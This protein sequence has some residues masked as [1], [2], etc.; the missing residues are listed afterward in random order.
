VVPPAFAVA[1]WGAKQPQLRANG[2]TRLPLRWTG[3]PCGSDGPAFQQGG[4]GDLAAVPTASHPPA[5]LCQARTTT[6][7]AL[8]VTHSI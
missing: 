6:R 1:P 8:I 7:S 5:A 3:H 4:G 2:R